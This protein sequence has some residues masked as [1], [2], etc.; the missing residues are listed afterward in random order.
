MIEGV[1][2]G[3]HVEPRRS[4]TIEPAVRDDR[5]RRDERRAAVRDR[6]RKDSVR[7]SAEGRAMLEAEQRSREA[8]REEARE[9]DA[10]REERRDER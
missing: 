3:G 8:R 9:D 6:D 10:R 1:T 7:I 5:S 2:R 4:E